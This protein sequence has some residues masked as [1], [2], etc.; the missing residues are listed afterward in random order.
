MARV[1]GA[2]APNRTRALSRA[3]AAQRARERAP[4]TLLHQ[5]RAPLPAICGPPRALYAPRSDTAHTTRSIRVMRRPLA[6]PTALRGALPRGEERPA[7]PRCSHLVA[8]AAGVERALEVLELHGALP[9]PLLAPTHP[10]RAAHGARVAPARR[11]KL[12]PLSALARFKSCRARVQLAS[13][14]LA[15]SAPAAAQ[16]ARGGGLPLAPRGAGQ[17]L[18]RRLA[19]RLPGC[20]AARLAGGGLAPPGWRG[21][22]PRP[23][24]RGCA[25]RRARRPC[26][27]C[28]PPQRARCRPSTTTMTLR[29]C[30]P[31]GAWRLGAL[32]RRPHARRPVRPPCA[33]LH[34]RLGTAGADAARGASRR[35]VRRQRLRGRGGGGGGRGAGCAAWRGRRRPPARAAA[36]VAGG[37]ECAAA[38]A[39]VRR[40]AQRPGGRNG[41]GE[42]ARGG[43]T[44]RDGGQGRGRWGKRQRSEF[45]GAQRRANLLV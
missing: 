10:P 8:P 37:C 39:P 28:R 24:R 38:S 43:A 42:R 23:R 40:A 27:A 29:R 17:G 26:A 1:A 35:A 6:P 12:L 30:V 7:A 41:G 33:C 9:T 5:P 34:G 4:R 31:P 21:G 16:R 2:R 44:D 32:R 14:H 45:S 22:V 20:A 19:A 3:R 13:L 25:A 15:A 18:L 11:S 36:T